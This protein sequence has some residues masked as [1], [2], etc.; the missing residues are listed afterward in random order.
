MQNTLPLSSPSGARFAPGAGPVPRRRRPRET[1]LTGTMPRMSTEPVETRRILRLRGGVAREEDDQVVVEEPLEIRID[2]EAF[3][4]LMRTPGHDLDLAAG[5]AMTEGVVDSFAAIGTLRH[6]ADPP[7]GGGH[8]ENAVEIGLVPGTRF[9]REGLR[10]NLV[11][12]AACG[13]CGRAALDSLGERA[14]VN[15]ARF[16]VPRAV[17]AALPDRLIEAQ[18]VF[19]STGAL[20]GAALFDLEG[21]P[22]VVRE[23]VGRHNAVDKAIGRAAI[24]GIDLSR[25]ILAVSGRT[26]FEILQKAAVASIPIVCA[27]SG[28]TTLAI[29]TARQF[30]ITLVNFVRPGGMN[31]ASCPERI[32]AE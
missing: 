24:D 17:L 31:I 4:I 1:A 8:P 29:D 26:S 20:H 15:D 25:S 5:F 19:R 27:V 22:L 3:A 30:G 32:A 13:L 18:T 10:R 6:C 16:T 12:S 11:A 21:R 9:D 23:D 2:G 28:P 7:A 14:R